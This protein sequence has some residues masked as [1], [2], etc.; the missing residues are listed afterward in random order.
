[1]AELGAAPPAGKSVEEYMAGLLELR[2]AY[3]KEKNFAGADRIRDVLKSLS[4][5][6]E[7]TAQGPRWHKVQ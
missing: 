6:V 4:V 7:D 5:V 3:R 2:Q 1:M